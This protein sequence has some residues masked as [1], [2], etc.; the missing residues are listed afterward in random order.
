MGRRIDL[1]E[2]PMIQPRRHPSR[3][4]RA[5]RDG[6]TD[7]L[8]LAPHAR[9]PR[10]LPRLSTRVR[11]RAQHAR[12]GRLRDDDLRRARALC[13]GDPRRCRVPSQPGEHRP[14][15]R[16]RR[17]A[18]DRTRPAAGG[19][20]R[21]RTAGQG[22]L[23]R[24]VLRALRPGSGGGRGR[25]EVPLR[26]VFRGSRHHRISPGPGCAGGRA[27]LGSRHGFVGGDGRLPVA[28]RRIHDGRVPGRDAGDP[29]RLL[30]VRRPGGCH[31]VA[32]SSAASPG[33][34]SGPRR[35]SWCC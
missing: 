26:A 17:R 27:A 3:L 29:A 8:F 15:H 31:A 34:C 32:G 12:D 21:R 35:S 25:V 33:R 30:R 20:A 19:P 1:D 18:P 6:V 13:P 2:Q 11:H 7:A 28:I 16:R 23:H 5:R 4:R 10:A 9:H 24:R 14:V 22:V